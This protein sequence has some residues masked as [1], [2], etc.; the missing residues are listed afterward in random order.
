MW[1]S[2]DILHQLG[3]A[4]PLLDFLLVTSNQSKIIQTAM[5]TEQEIDSLVDAFSASRA[6]PSGSK[7]EVTYAD[8]EKMLDETPLFMRSTPEG[9]EDNEVL[10]GLRSLIFEG[11]GDGQSLYLA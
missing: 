9:M 7:K 4:A 3:L 5:S 2:T 8:F 10:Q 6:G 11:E 1:S